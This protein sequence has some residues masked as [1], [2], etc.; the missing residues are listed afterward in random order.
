MAD[1][2]NQVPD[3]P[4]EPEDDTAGDEPMPAPPTSDDPSAFEPKEPGS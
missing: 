3:D 1:D 4:N 2:P